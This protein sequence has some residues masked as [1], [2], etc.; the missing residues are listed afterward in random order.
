MTVVFTPFLQL[1]DIIVPGDVY[2]LNNTVFLPD[3]LAMFHTLF[4]VANTV[5]CSFF[6][7]QIAHVV[8]FL[9]PEEKEEAYRLQ[10]VSATLQDTPELYMVTVK[11]ELSKMADIVSD[12]FHRFWET[13]SHPE[14]RLAEAVDKQKEMEDLTDKMQEE[15]TK[16]LSQCS[17]DK[18][19]R[20]SGTNVSNMMRIA[21]ELEGI[22]DNC[23][24]LIILAE[25]RAKQKLLINEV[26]ME[27]LQPYIDLVNR[28]LQFIRSH[29]NEHITSENMTVAV[30]L[31]E[32]INT[33]R[34][35]L[36]QSAANRLQNGEDV[37]KELLY[38]DIVRHIEQIG[39]H[40]L[41]ITESLRQTS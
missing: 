2:A 21:H 11:R 32:S 15:I 14:K 9:V 13:F 41:N 27:E 23:F 30:K 29:L 18:M 19:N 10:Y 8:Q 3:H 4:N 35:T 1:V 26:E 6:V 22:G 16:F 34:N 24:N 5:L 7:K 33:M 37:R 36:R 38:I 40:C 39:D 31:E 12:M 17:L 28:F 25:R 20:V